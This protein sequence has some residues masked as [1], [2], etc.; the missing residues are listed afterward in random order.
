MEYQ[1]VLRTPELGPGQLHEVEAHGEAVV[2]ANV[3][4]TYH[5]LSARC[6]NDDVN[7]AQEG[8]LQGDLLICPN[9]DWA[10]DVRTG[11]R[12]RP[13]GGPGLRRYPIEI[14]EN[15]IKVGPPQESRG[16]A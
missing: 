6:P 9:D 4:Q 7:L 3:G 13:S 11:R 8:R 15:V 1:S 14:E 10:F 16:A 2:L 5:A 12:V